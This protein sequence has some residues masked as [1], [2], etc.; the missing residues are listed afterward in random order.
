[1]AR[2]IDGLERYIPGT[3]GNA[4]AA[5]QL[6]AGVFV[7][8][9]ASTNAAS[10]LVFPVDNRGIIAAVIGS[11][12][13]NATVTMTVWGVIP[14]KFADLAE[15]PTAGVRFKLGSFVA[16]FG[17]TTAGGAVTGLLVSGERFAD[18]LVWT[19]A[20]AGGSPEGPG[21][22]FGAAFG[23]GDASVYSPADNSIAYLVYPHV[24][25]WGVIFE[26]TATSGSVTYSNLLI[27]RSG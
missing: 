11:A 13:D 8:A 20:T 14:S 2:R 12:A 15:V 22:V 21:A 4:Q 10:H 6:A 27:A 1:M 5:A 25:G 3:S 26:P 17:T 23:L 7:T 18:T 24:P 9:D 16:T 19:A